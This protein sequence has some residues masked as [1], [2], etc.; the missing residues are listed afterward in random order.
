MRRGEAPQRERVPPRSLQGWRWQE[1]GVWF[2]SAAAVAAAELPICWRGDFET[3]RWCCSLLGG[4]T[5]EGVGGS[6]GEGLGTWVL[7]GAE[8]SGMYQKVCAS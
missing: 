8:G 2:A 6:G 3:S 5:R 1:S 4:S 7:E